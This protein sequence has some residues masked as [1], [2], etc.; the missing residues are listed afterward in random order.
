M[1]GFSGNKTHKNGPCPGQGFISSYGSALPHQGLCV[2]RHQCKY[3]EQL[4]TRDLQQPS[5]S[6]LDSCEGILIKKQTGL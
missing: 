1:E 3:F 2:T 5:P 6:A 4:K